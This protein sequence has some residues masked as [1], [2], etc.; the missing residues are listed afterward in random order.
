M[1]GLSI[2]RL[3]TALRTMI[4]RTTSEYNRD[5]SHFFYPTRHSFP[6]ILIKYAIFARASSDDHASTSSLLTFRA[7]NLA[8][9]AGLAVRFCS[10]S[11]SMERAVFIE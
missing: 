7:F 9:I 10:F 11:A 3:P 6:T 2:R 5:V 1:D 4:T 8:R